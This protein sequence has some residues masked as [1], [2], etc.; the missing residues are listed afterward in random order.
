MR[1]KYPELSNRVRHQHVLFCPPFKLTAFSDG[2]FSFYNIGTDPDEQHDLRPSDPPELRPCLQR[3]RQLE[4]DGFYT[5]FSVTFS[6]Q[7]EDEI[8]ESLRAL[9]YV[10]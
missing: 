10:Q 8:L 2:L 3:Y 1:E 9:G 7:P 4:K 6:E 5:P